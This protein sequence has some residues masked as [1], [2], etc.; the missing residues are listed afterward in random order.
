MNMNFIQPV[1]IIMGKDCIKKNENIF[2]SFG[3]RCLIVTG[4][5]SARKSGALEDVTNALSNMGIQYKVFSEIEQNPS[6]A[7]CRKAADFGKDLKP[8]FII[9]IGGGSPL[10]AAKAIAVL[11]ANEDMSAEDLYS[12]EWPSKPLPIIA[13]GTTAG[14]GSEVTSV[15][16][17]TSPAGVKKSFRAPSLFPAVCFGDASYTMSLSTEFTRSTALD[18]LC[19]CVESYFNRT[20]ND[21]S[22]TFALRG[23]SILLEMLDKTAQGDGGMLSF[24]DREKLYCASLYG[25]LA[26]SITGTA[27]PHTMGYFLSEQY[28]VSHGNA[29]AIYLEEFINHNVNVVPDIADTFFDALKTDRA[30]LLSL[31]KRNLPDIQIE[32]SNEKIQELLPRFENN[33]SLNKCLGKVDRQYAQMLL[34][35]MFLFAQLPEGN[36]TCGSNI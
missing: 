21:V 24:E 29:C 15:S 12:L 35:K 26:I 7:S 32:L 28:K 20:A 30:T 18:A 10:D 33:K 4:S 34:E 17:I 14:T 19:H 23:I 5:A 27:F 13:V 6:Y 36:S 25:G 31:I 8:D 2:L 16:V 1:N 3:K 22:R 9:G 11:S